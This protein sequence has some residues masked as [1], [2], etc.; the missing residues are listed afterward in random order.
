MELPEELPPLPSPEQRS[1]GTAEG[2]GFSILIPL[3][4]V[5]AIPEVMAGQPVVQDM[6]GC[7]MWVEAVVALS[8]VPM[9]HKPDRRAVQ[10]PIQSMYPDWL[11]LALPQQ[12][13]I[14]LFLRLSR[15]IQGLAGLLLLF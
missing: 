6:P 14:L 1:M 7:R 2:E 3:Q 9:A 5:A 10:G 12:F 4:Q 11:R 15:P 13:L 8:G